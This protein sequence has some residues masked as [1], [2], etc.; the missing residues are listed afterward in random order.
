MEAKQ[1]TVMDLMIAVSQCKGHNSTTSSYLLPVLLKTSPYLGC[2]FCGELFPFGTGMMMTWMMWVPAPSQAC[3]MWLDPL[4]AL[5]CRAQIWSPHESPIY[6]KK[7]I[8]APKKSK[9]DHR[10]D[11]GDG[12]FWPTK[13][14]KGDFFS[15]KFTTKFRGTWSS[16][17]PDF[18]SVRKMYRKGM[19]STF[20]SP[21]GRWMFGSRAGWGPPTLQDLQW[22]ILGSVQDDSKVK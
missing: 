16:T 19:V 21:R 10:N 1:L 13:V 12:H 2:F 5:R 4:D 7:H 6:E 20:G 17:S 11:G 15:P 3:T 8:F 9:R 14:T 22:E 18:S